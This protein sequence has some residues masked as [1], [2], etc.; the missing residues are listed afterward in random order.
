[1]IV[2]DL[3][4]QIAELTLK[5][6]QIQEECSHPKI[7]VT[8]K[9]GSNTGNYDPSADSYWMDCHCLLCDKTWREDQ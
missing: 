7:A 1:M 4:K 8:K 9:P 6:R 2:L 3:Q 5:I